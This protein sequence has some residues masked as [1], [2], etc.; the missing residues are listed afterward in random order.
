MFLLPVPR[1]MPCEHCGAS[2]ERDDVA[3]RCDEERRVEFAFFQLRAG[4][5]MF[6]EHLSRWLATACGRFE[7]YYAERTRPA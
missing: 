2:I 1:H 6:E 4:I 5:E 7:R 3:H